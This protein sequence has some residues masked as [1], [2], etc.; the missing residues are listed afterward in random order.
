[1]V[2]GLCI[3]LY[4][5]ELKEAICVVNIYGPYFERE[6][7]WN[8]LFSMEFLNCSKLVLGGD[9]NFFVGFSEIWGE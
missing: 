7:Y 5:I 1:M 9:L 8:N 4:S 6:I 2:S 3:S